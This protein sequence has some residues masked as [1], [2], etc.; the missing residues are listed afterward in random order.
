MKLWEKN[1][2]L[3]EKI[4]KYTVG[5]DYIIDQKLVKYD[6]IASIAHAKMLEKISIISKTESENI[7][8]ELKNII[9]LNKNGKFQIKLE[10]E[11]CH[12]AI[13]NYLIEKLGDTG[14]KIHTARS[15]NDQVLTALRLYYKD[16]IKQIE[17][18]VQNLM[19]SI[20][21]FKEK[22]G[23]IDLPGYT[24]MRKAMPS[25]IFLWCDAFIESM[26]DNGELLNLIY[27]QIDKSPLGTAAGYGIPLKIDR[28]LTADLLG[29]EKIQENPLYV[30]NS[31]GKFESLILE[32]L[33]QIMF[34]LNKISSDILLFSMSEFGFFQ[35]SSKICTGSS[36]MPHKKNPDVLEITRANYHKLISYESEIKNIASN[37]ISGYH[38]DLQ[39]TK[40]PMIKGFDLVKGS[41]DIMAI[42]FE[43]LTMNQDKCKKAM[44]E[45]LFSTKNIYK[46]VEK[47]FPFREAYKKY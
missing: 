38:R 18:S 13:E 34:D 7:Q 39:L 25:S 12:T 3:D 20:S 22:Y 9:K 17:N 1:Y 28:K 36:I 35:L 16:E 46:S 27:K 23:Y 29:F 40:E 30:Q 15:R 47:G 4:E 45:E 11:D 8:K 44:T 19:K 5:N 21:N 26:H 6:C 14:K 37:L 33:S 2:K 31:R 42:V 32:G 43:N 24:H 41:L 10:G